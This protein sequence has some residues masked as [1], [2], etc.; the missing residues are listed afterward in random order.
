MILKLKPRSLG[1]SVL[2][3]VLAGFLMVS[4]VACHRAVHVKNVPTGV[5]EQS[6]KNWYAAVG[7]FKMA[8]E[9][10]QKLTNSAI[11]LHSEFP[12]EASYQK[13]LEG[14]GRMAQVEAQAAQFLDTAPQNWNQPI[15][16]QIQ[17]YANSLAGLL[18]TSVEDGLAHVK[19]PTTA[20]ALKTTVSLLRGAIQT[21][22]ALTQ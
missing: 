21:A 15:A 22:A 12:D 3:A 5:S 4:T 2:V 8:A 6:V 1:L 18:T 13:T 9:T 16:T 11:A 19:N 17:S 7:A 14:L 10:T 20:A